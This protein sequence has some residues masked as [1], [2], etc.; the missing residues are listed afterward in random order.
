MKIIE[1]LGQGAAFQTTHSVLIL[2]V[3][4]GCSMVCLAFI[5]ERWIYFRRIQI[6]PERVLLNIRS[7]LLAG[8]VDEAL[9]ILG[10]ASGNPVLAV[11]Q[12]GVVHSQMP[13]E[14]VGEMM[15]ACQLK[16]RAA[17]ERNLGMLGTLGNT[18]PFIGL[19]GTVLGIIQAFHDLAGPQAAASGASVVAIGIAEALVATAAGLTVAI[20]A[21][22][23]YNFFL[24]KVKQVLVDMEA[25]TLEMVVLLS[26][27]TSEATN[28]GSRAR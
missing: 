8:R 4:I 13:K 27:R 14:Q 16:Q 11:I 2:G 20:P 22:I 15:R 6:N 9:K 26:L 24:R 17:M 5:V 21:V 18:A 3:L 25:A 19:L 7:S 1:A 23:F 28:G 12:A 10:D